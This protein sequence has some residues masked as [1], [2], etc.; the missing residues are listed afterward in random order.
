MTRE[1]L[2]GLLA[3]VTERRREYDEA[4]D[5]AWFRDKLDAALAAAVTA[6]LKA[7]IAQSQPEDANQA[8]RIGASM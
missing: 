3:I 7:L 1:E 2:E 6:C 5:K 8:V 4:Y